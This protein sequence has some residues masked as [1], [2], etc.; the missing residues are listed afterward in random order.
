MAEK[1]TGKDLKEL[2]QPDEFQLVAGKALEW[3][4]A[5]RRTLVIA[6]AAIAAVAVIAIGA[7]AYKQH[8]EGKAGEA[9]AEALRLEARPV[10]GEGFPQPGEETFPSKAERTKAATAALEAVRKDH[11]GST[12]AQ[13]AA[14][15]LGL[16]KQQTGDPQGA[17]PLLQEFLKDAPSGHPMRAVAL[18]SLGYAAQA[19]GKAAEAREAF[20][21]LKDAGAPERGAYQ[22]ARLDLVEGKPNA[23]EALAAVG[24]DYPK[25]PVAMEANLRLE[26]ASIPPAPAGSAKADE[27]VAEP[28]KAPPKA[29]P[30]KKKGK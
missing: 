3:I 11:A 29:A 5:H 6:A 18:E 13:T 22:L 26:V 7:A 16:L 17:T 21:K 14:L 24:K 20:G 15:Q 25:D 27:P 9:L 30:K 10:A 4:L 23:R 2:R 19:Q 12:A 28:V 8:R 1:I